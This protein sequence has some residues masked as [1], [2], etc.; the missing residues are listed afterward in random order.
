MLEAAKERANPPEGPLTRAFRAGNREMA[1]Q[2]C[3]GVQTKV[4]SLK[5]QHWDL[6]GV[7]DQETADKVER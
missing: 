4:E 2:M 3:G 7:G 1:V 6:L 5:S